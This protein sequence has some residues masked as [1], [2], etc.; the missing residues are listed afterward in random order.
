MALV[1]VSAYLAVLGA[2]DLDGRKIARSSTA[3]RVRGRDYG[4]RNPGAY[5]NASGLVLPSTPRTATRDN[6][7]FAQKPGQ[8]KCGGCRRLRTHSHHCHP[9]VQDP[10]RSRSGQ[11]FAGS[12]DADRRSIPDRMETK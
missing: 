8:G 12:L 10:Q 2:F 5:V 9:A 6:C 1:I 7:P 3:S 11:K 4:N